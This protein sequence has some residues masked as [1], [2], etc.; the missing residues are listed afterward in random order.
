MMVI[1]FLVMIFITI[2]SIA[3]SLGVPGLNG[4]VPNQV[5]FGLLPANGQPVIPSAVPAVRTPPIIEPVGDPSECL[6]LK[7]M[8]DP[9]TEVCFVFYH[10]SS[11]LS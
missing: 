1:Y 5:G 8:F 7:N 10:Q 9:S 3:E 4:A 11:L 6:L 2:C